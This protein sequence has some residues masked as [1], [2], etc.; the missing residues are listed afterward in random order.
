MSPLNQL[1]YLPLGE[2]QTQSGLHSLLESKSYQTSGQWQ[3][4]QKVYA[5][6][7]YSIMYR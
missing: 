6:E 2:K 3:R 4:Y 1:P 7:Y 5:V